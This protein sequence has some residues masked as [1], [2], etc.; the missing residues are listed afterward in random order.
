VVV[1][2]MVCAVRDWE[3]RE[4]A[5]SPESSANSRKGSAVAGLT[6]LWLVVAGSIRVS[7]DNLISFDPICFRHV[8]HVRV[9]QTLF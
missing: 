5:S 6:N 9:R 3:T 8:V 2:Q 7:A 4:S 1:S